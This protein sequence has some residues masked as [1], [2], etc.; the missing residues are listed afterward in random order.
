MVGAEAMGKKGDTR[1]AS[2]AVAGM[3]HS[4]LSGMGGVLCVPGGGDKQ[5]QQCNKALR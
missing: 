5:K 3:L 4:E 1:L 2:R